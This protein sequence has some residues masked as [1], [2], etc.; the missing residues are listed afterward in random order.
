MNEPYM[1][2]LDYVRNEK[3][4]PQVISNSYADDEQTTPKAYAIRVCNEFA[5]LGARGVTVLFGAGNFGVGKTG[6][7]IS[8]DGKNRTTFLPAFPASCPYVTAVGATKN[9]D[10]EVAAFDATP[11]IPNPKNFSTAGG[12]SNYFPR[13]AYQ[14]DVVA[15]YVKSLGKLYKGLYNPNG[16]G[17]P[18]ISAQGQRVV[19][20]WNGKD[21]PL[22]G[23]SVATAVAS[24]ILT[25]VNDALIAQ[26]KPPLGFLNP[27]LY[28]KGFKALT[29][30]TSGSA[31]GCGVDGF[32]AQQGWDAVTG[33]GTPVS[34]SLALHFQCRACL[35]L[36]LPPILALVS[37]RKT[38]RKYDD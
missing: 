29:D 17:L 27:W 22:V 28:S 31:I 38:K 9:F 26:G 6:T 20:V 18:D 1:I 7:C 8:N 13:P 21:L 35:F 30:I 33:F 15:P 34:L 32:P 2:W 11:P 19:T 5:Q 37:C 23:T 24:S 14:E 12:F 3:K 16:R 36:V 25:L 10:P 4:L